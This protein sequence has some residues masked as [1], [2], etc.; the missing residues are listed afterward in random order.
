MFIEESNVDRGC[1]RQGDI[2]ERIPFPL[3]QLEDLTVLGKINSQPS[4]LPYPN[5]DT[6]LTTHRK[7]P[8]FFTGQ[9]LM[10][11]SY[12]VVFSHCCE[13]EPRNG[14]MFGSAF[15]VARLVPIKQSILEDRDKLNSLRANPDPRSGIPSYIDYFH[16]ASNPK[17]ENKEWMVDF[18]QI[19]SIPKT[20]FPGILK[21]KILQMDDRTRVKF[22]I[23]A[24]AY[25]GRITEEEA[26]GAFMNRGSKKQNNPYFIEQNQT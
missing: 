14:K 7:D 11:L 2:L 3:L 26:Q 10:R 23:K 22:K 17:T 4:E 21:R 20:E 15:T 9:A 8:N 18:A 13:L 25:F 1:L 5:I 6:A 16:I 19:V 12:G 24:A